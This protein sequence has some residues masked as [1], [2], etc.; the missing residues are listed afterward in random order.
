MAAAECT[1]DRL[2]PSLKKDVTTA[3]GILSGLPDVRRIW[4][5]GSVAKGRKPD[6]RSDLDLAV[7]GLRA[8]DHFKALAMLDDSLELPPDLVRWEEANPLLREEIQHW[9]ILVYDRS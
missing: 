6:F 7:E 1:L 2:E 8:E 9:G 3:V 4:L 5:F